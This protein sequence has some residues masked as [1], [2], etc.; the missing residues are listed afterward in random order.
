MTAPSTSSTPLPLI[1]SAIQSIAQNINNQTQN[2]TNLQ[3][4]TSFTGLTATTV[5]KATS[6]R[7][8][9]ISVIVP[10]SA[11][12]MAYDSNTTTN[13]SR[14]LFIIPDTAGITVVNMPFQ[15]GL[16]I[17]PGSGQTVSGSYS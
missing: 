6:G 16:L 15:Y 9:N 1:L 10:G 4:S 8:E 13:T 7:L 14:P 3:G 17:V 11:A 12:G 2:Q 5:V